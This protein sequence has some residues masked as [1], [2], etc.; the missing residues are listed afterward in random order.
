MKQKKGTIF[1]RGALFHCYLS[2]IF[3][4]NAKFGVIN[5][6]EKRKTLALSLCFSFLT[7]YCIKKLK[8]LAKGCG[9]LYHLVLILF[10][11]I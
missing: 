2:A 3:T 9:D 11:K 10:C 1:R 4:G 7:I 6:R 5:L 8:E